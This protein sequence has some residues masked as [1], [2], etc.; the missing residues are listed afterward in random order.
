MAD[1]I[2]I[3]KRYTIPN[4]RG[5]HGRTSMQIVS[6]AANWWAVHRI[7]SATLF[8][9]NRVL[10]CRSIVGIMEMGVIKGQEIEI[11]VVGRDAVE[12]IREI[13]LLFARHFDE[14]KYE[15]G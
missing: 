8:Y 10:D 4:W 9:K 13:D 14:D 12:F 7:V 1:Q 6:L 5:L 3:K 11:E 15:Y 2:R